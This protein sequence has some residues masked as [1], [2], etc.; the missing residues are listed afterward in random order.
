MNKSHKT[1]QNIGQSLKRLARKEAHK[2]KKELYPSQNL[3]PVARY[4]EQEDY[5]GPQPDIKYPDRF[6]KV[7][8][9]IKEK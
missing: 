7:G 1:S 3:D 4:N 8:N 5:P 6:S 2:L 9:P